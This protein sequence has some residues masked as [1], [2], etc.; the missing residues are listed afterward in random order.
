M[1]LN[2][3]PYPLGINIGKSKSVPLE[4]AAEDYLKSFLALDDFADYFTVNVSS[5][6]T[7]ELRKLQNKEFLP[8]LLKTLTDANEKRAATLGTKPIPMLLKI[9]PDLS[10]KEVDSII[11]TLL[12][13]RFVG[14]IATNTTVA[15]F[16][17]MGEITESGG[18]SGAPLH[19]R[20]CEFINYIHRHT[21]GKLPIIGVG[22]IVDER[23]AG[24]TM[25]AGAS[26]IQIYTGWIF[27]GPFFPRALAR[28]ME[29]RSRSW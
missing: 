3:T 16:P 24:Q 21:E 15:R 10:F 1:H 11:E 2:K 23:T 29:A 8:H 25:D 17:G 26:L 9:A 28:A 20:S 4:Q 14:I 27:R 12:A 6:N 18:L 7:P 5:P 22:G 13:N 19:R